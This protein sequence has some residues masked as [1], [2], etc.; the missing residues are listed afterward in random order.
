M[1]IDVLQVKQ[2]KLR[3]ESSDIKEDLPLRLRVFEKFPERPLMTRWEGSKTPFVIQI[4]Y[5][6][7]YLLIAIRNHIT[8]RK[9][10][11]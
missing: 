10:S 2:L 4:K 1:I 3:E 5:F 9:I 7:I 8:S 6:H 11:F